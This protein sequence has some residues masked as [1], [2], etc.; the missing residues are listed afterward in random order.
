MLL[1][2]IDWTAQRAGDFAAAVPR[3]PQ[4]GVAAGGRVL[5]AAALYL[6]HG[7]PHQL[8][9]DALTPQ[10]VVHIGVVDDVDAVPQRERHLAHLLAALDGV[11]PVLFC[12]VFHCE[13]VSVLLR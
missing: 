7:T 13:C 4:L 3:Q 6:L 9:G 2:S 1:V 5:S 12:D 11:Y 8:A 10:A